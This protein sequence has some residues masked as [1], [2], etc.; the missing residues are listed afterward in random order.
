MFC[1]NDAIA[2]RPSRA[3]PRLAPQP[4]ATLAALS[5]AT[6]DD[7]IRLV[8]AGVIAFIA[9]PGCTAADV[10]RAM[11]YLPFIH[12]RTLARLLWLAYDADRQPGL[13]PRAARPADAQTATPRCPARGSGPTDPARLPHAAPSPASHTQRSWPVAGGPGAP[14]CTGDE[15][16]RCRAAGCRG[17]RMCCACL[18]C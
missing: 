6:Q 4:I 8:E 1:P 2:S 13:Q 14:A 16:C 18:R 10:D 5:E 9:P 7:L 15:R 12:D 17:V 11:A 3:E